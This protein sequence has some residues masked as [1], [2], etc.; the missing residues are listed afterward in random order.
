MATYQYQDLINYN[1]TIYNKQTQQAYSTPEALAK[2]LGMAAMPENWQNNP[3]ITPVTTLPWQGT[4]TTPSYVRQTGTQD[5]YNVSGTQ[6]QYVTFDQANQQNLW[7]QVRDLPSLSSYGINDVGPITDQSPTV[8][9][10]GNTTT[11]LTNASA[12]LQSA[13]MTLEK[14]YN[15]QI[16][17][18]ASQQKALQT[19]IDAYQAKEETALGELQTLSTPWQEDYETNERQRLMVE[20]NYFDNQNSV[21][22]L[23]TLM[24]KAVADIQYTEQVTGLSSIRNPRI[25]QIKTDYA[26]RVGVVEAVMAARNNQ[27]SVA[28]NLI[29]RGIKAIANDK[30]AEIDYYGTV[31]DFYDGLRTEAGDRLI[32]LSDEEKTY[33]KAK[34]G[35]LENDLATLQE[36]QNYIKELMVDPATARAMEQA[37]VKLTDSIETING[38]LSAYAYTKEV[39]DTANTLTADGYRQLLPQEVAA[40]SADKIQV[41]TDSR[42]NKTYWYNPTRNTEKTTGTG[43]DNVYTFEDPTTGKTVEVDLGTVEGVQSYVKSNPGITYEEMK[44]MLDDKLTGVTA[45][46]IEGLLAAAGLKPS[47]EDTDITAA[48]RKII[49]AIQV[50]RDAGE[51]IETVVQR[52]RSQG[53]KET[54]FTEYL[55]NW[56]TT[57]KWYEGSFWGKLPFVK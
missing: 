28:T 27:I 54:D 46:S 39:Q 3:A 21:K 25:S 55:A 52:I 30:Q 48:K 1:N 50:S 11:Y 47:V 26:A 23:E 38:K 36:T 56:P 40:Y 45:S 4:T 14:S 24:N 18:L 51:D 12:D 9:A 57:K 41:S 8:Q 10:G 49:G 53:Y 13:R 7:G 35:M 17:S 5:V 2:D 16:Q 34:I 31:M 20:Q 43:S 6:P 19:K 32:D 22:E 29:D 33:V 37:G 42:G 15:T 44:V